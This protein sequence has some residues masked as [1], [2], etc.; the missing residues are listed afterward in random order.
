MPKIMM[1]KADFKREHK[2]LVKVLKAAKTPAAAR[3]L[4]LQRAEMRNVL[5]RPKKLK[6]REDDAMMHLEY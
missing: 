6:R 2:R 5:A 3:E 1:D 4:R